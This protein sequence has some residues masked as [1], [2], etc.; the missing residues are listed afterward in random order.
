MG[1]MDRFQQ[2]RPDRV[3]LSRAGL[4][5]AA[6]LLFTMLTPAHARV[7]VETGHDLYGFCLL[8]ADQQLARPGERVLGKAR[9]CR[10]YV[11]GFFGS[12]Q[13]LQEG[14]GTRKLHDND[15]PE[16]FQC[17]LVPHAAT[18]Q[19]LERQIIRY[20]DWNPELLDEPAIQLIQRAF[21]T[22]DPC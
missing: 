2:L 8:A 7:R 18:F 21:N 6:L 17:S 22:L 11:S 19:Q 9:Y 16:R 10:Q 14:E 3:I 13:A 12:L 1:T 5:L 15:D 20:G 4:V